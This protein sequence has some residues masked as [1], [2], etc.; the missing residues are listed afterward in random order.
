MIG[1]PAFRNLKLRLKNHESNVY[2]LIF[3]DAQQYLL[4]LGIFYY[5]YIDFYD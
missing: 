2:Y 3:P 1:F 5:K 4:A